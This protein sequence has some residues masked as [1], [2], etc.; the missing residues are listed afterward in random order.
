MSEIISI[1][2]TDRKDGE[3]YVSFLKRIVSMAADKRISYA[4][5]GDALLGSENVYSEDNLRKAFYVLTKI[6]DKLE[7]DIIYESNDFVRDIREQKRQLEEAKIQ[8]RDERMAYNAQNRN[9][10]R[11]E[12]KLEYLENSLKELGNERFIPANIPYVNSDNDMLIVLSDLHIGQCFNSTFGSFNSDIAKDRLQQYLKSICQIRERHNSKRAYVVLAGDLISNS[13]HKSL[14]ITNRE[15]V[16]DQIKLAIDYISAFCFELSK[17]FENVYLT[18]CAGNH[19]RIDR[20]EDALHDERL[21]TL[22]SWTVSKLLQN[23]NN[24]KVIE[25]SRIDT[26]IAE[27][28]IRGKTYVAVHGDYDDFSKRSMAQLSMML[29]HIPYACI[30]GH[31]HFPAVTD[32][33]GVRIIQSGSLSG[34]G[35]A[36]TTEKR[37]SGKPSQTVC[38]CTENGVECV[39]PIMLK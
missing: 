13:I 12:Q 6:S 17:Q 20:K 37:L 15:N 31:R 22:I 1:S 23:V 27:F 35:D 21:D 7:N 19:S 33:S 34:S 24:F 28:D 16:I 4:E 3:N 11:L 36:Y 38:I 39:Y 26:G 5:M 18:D 9:T 29:G 32:E 10:A 25:E 2:S 8:F 14:A 30:M